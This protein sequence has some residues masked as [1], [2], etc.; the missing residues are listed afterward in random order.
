MPSNLSGGVVNRNLFLLV[1]II[2]VITA[3]VDFAY[4]GTY[5]FTQTTPFVFG[6]P[7]ISSD[8]SVS[9]VMGNVT[10]VNVTLNGVRVNTF[11][12]GIRDTDILLVN[13]TGQKVILMSF[14]CNVTPGPLDFTFDGAASGPLPSGFDTTCVSGTF[15][16]SD[17]SGL[18]GGY[19]LDPPA[20]APPYSTDMDQFN[21]SN[22]N[23]L[24]KMWAREFA[25]NQGGTI[26]TWTLA[27]TTDSDE[28]CP[29]GPNITTSTLPSGRELENYN[30]TV[31][32]IGGT[33]PYTWSYSG[34]LPEGFILGSETGQILG[35]PSTG[36]AGTYF[37]TIH[38]VDS[39]G[40]SDSETFSINIGLFDLCRY[41]NQFDDGTLEWIEE[42][43]TVTESSGS[44]N[45]TPFKNKSIAVAD[46]AFSGASNG[47]YTFDI[48]FTGGANSK[49]WLY[50]TRIDKKNSLEV[51][52]KTDQGKVVI[53]DRLGS[54]RA[55][56]KGNF[57]FTPNTPYTFVTN[58]DGNNVDVTIN[59]TPVIVDFVPSRVLPSA[60]IGAAVKNGSLSI[61]DVCVE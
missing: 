34:D 8:L 29:T 54:I 60:N 5:T 17:Y 30:Q 41:R 42:K 6:D 52:A 46:A 48:Q 49:N 53:K 55:K 47:T 45:L 25:G 27:I 1:L 3:V 51:L 36:S 15:L 37:F 4:S 59:G 39:L 13:P 10:D 23:G 19:I 11:I 44:L 9:G 50:I 38:V 2:A 58:Y 35:F 12:N 18:A 20:P 26:D 14:V 7:T 31:Q 28:D 33:P 21:G 22:P 57:T 61:N 43:A 40:C 32:A 56:A 24:W 16:P